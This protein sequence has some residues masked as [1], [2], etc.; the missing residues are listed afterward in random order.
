MNN[1]CMH[2]MGQLDANGNCPRC[3]TQTPAECAPHQLVPGTILLGRYLVG[4]TIGQGGFGITYIGRDLLLDELVAVKE[5]YPT[6]YANR[7]TGASDKVTVTGD[8][9]GALYEHG[10][11]RFLEEARILAKYRGEPG[12]VDVL[13][14]FE[15][16]GTAYIVMEYLDG[17]D[18]YETLA[19]TPTMDANWVFDAFVPILDALE[20]MH[21]DH[22]YHRDVSPD[23]IMLLGDGTLRLMDFGAARS[24][25]AEDP[26]S[27]SV[28]LKAG[29]APEE[30]YAKNGN[31]GPWTD[32]YALCATMYKCIT[33]ITP[34]DAVSRRAG[35]SLV[36]PSALGIGMSKQLENVIKKGMSLD[37]AERFQSIAEMRGAIAAAQ[38]SADSNHPRTNMY[39][40]ADEGK[41][42]FVI[43]VQ[44]HTPEA[45][46]AKEA[47]RDDEGFNGMQ[48]PAPSAYCPACGN[49]LGAEDAFCTNCGK[50][51]T[52]MPA[53]AGLS[54]E[55]ANGADGHTV[56]ANG[57]TGNPATNHPQQQ[58]EPPKRNTV[59][60]TQ[61]KR[62]RTPQIAAAIAVLVAVI[63][64][65]AVLVL[66]GQESKPGN[67]GGESPAAT[68]V[69]A[70][71]DLQSYS[72]DELA[73]ISQEIG[74]TASQEEAI[75]VAKKYNLVDADGKLKPTDTKLVEV[76][77]A[78]YPVHIIGFAH[79]QKHDGETA[80]ITLQF[81]DCLDTHAMNNTR[82]S[83]AEFE[84]YAQ[85][86]KV[87]V[88][89]IRGDHPEA[90]PTNEGGWRDSSMRDWLATNVFPELPQE[91]RD[92]IVAA[93]KDTNNE[94]ETSDADA[95]TTTSDK[96][97][98]PS[99]AEICG[100]EN[101]DSKV[102]A[103]EGTAY[104]L[105]EEMGVG[106]KGD[107]DL[108]KLLG[109]DSLSYW[110]LRSAAASS[111]VYFV[112]VDK[113]GEFN[114]GWSDV[115]HGVAPCFCI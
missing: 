48:T 62:S 111:D 13:N 58:V 112:N 43:P 26:R 17:T 10:K 76:D 74:Q 95:V 49:K 82:S 63:A 108:K 88:E 22:V 27:V 99:K 94:G 98:L 64:I 18:L 60:Q 61:P 40:V 30:Q 70:K 3:G 19:T 90:V 83:D 77:G 81:V 2:C 46:V 101:C 100:P 45:G 87:S 71:D 68:A 78:D 57:T 11:E 20:R 69:E 39:G 67:V 12:I 103:A 28:M 41:T 110:W 15:S 47:S 105:F 55:G 92:V 42:R 6:G 31:L 44:A 107:T 91:L 66:P 24:I 50:R 96:L 37:A 86:R 113:D 85:K 114:A 56:A 54:G 4:E 97:W 79:D 38:S 25:L 115:K 21:A 80:G 53:A 93:E 35:A 72:W 16:N 29:Y 59:T 89:Q 52:M 33:G 34:A 14:F 23:N 73:T 7:N 102:T 104:Q 5:F 1:Y 51:V 9:N 75:E 8:K 106:A 84:Q 36:W 32:I 109:G 65:V